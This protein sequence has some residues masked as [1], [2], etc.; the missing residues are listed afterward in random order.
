MDQLKPLRRGLQAVLTCAAVLATMAL[1]ACAG[2][3]TS[4]SVATTTQVSAAP[5][6]TGPEPITAEEK[7]WVDGLTKLQKRLERRALRGGVVT[8]SRLLSDARLYNSC[9]RLVGTE[10]SARFDV[11]H[12]IA[13]KACGRFHKAATELR[14]AARNLDANSAIVSGTPQERNFNRAFGRGFNYAGN[15]VDQMLTAVEKAEAVKDALPS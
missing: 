10:P 14:T 12:R 13:R 6:T 5:T 8:R 11:A 7:E 1:V 2:T 4:K 9:K 3:S 15:G